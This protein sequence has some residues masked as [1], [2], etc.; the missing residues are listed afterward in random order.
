[1]EFWMMD[2]EMCLKKGEIKT[3]RKNTLQIAPEINSTIQVIKI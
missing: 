1:M 2:L 3:E